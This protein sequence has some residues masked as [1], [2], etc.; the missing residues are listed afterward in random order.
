METTRTALAPEH[1]LEGDG[2]L[3]FACEPGELPDEDFLEGSLGLGGLVDH[4]AELRPVGDAT[5]LGLVHELACDEV[6]LLLGIVPERP[7]AVTAHGQVHVLPVAGDPSV[8]GHWRVVVSFNHL[9]L[10]LVSFCPVWRERRLS[11]RS[12]LRHSLS[13]R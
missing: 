7:A 1:G 11:I 6:S 10:L 2:V 4:L 13:S 9:F 5:A 8:E 3:A 12:C